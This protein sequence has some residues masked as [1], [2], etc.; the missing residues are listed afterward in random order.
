MS[1]STTRRGEIELDTPAGDDET[2]TGPDPVTVPLSYSIAALTL[3]LVLVTGGLATAISV[4]AGN[5]AVSET[6]SE[7]EVAVRQCFDSGRDNVM[8]LAANMLHMASSELTN[9]LSAQFSSVEAYT[10]T[11][12]KFLTMHGDIS[13]QYLNQTVREVMYSYYTAAASKSLTQSI[14]M[15]ASN[16]HLPFNEAFKG[17]YSEELFLDR[18]RIVG[19]IEHPGTV[20]R[21]FE[22]FHM[23]LGVEC[24]LGPK[25]KLELGDLGA[26]VQLGTP[27]EFGQVIVLNPDDPYS[28]KGCNLTAPYL[29]NGKVPSGRC[30]VPESLKHL[31]PAM[32]EAWS[33][34]PMEIRWSGVEAHANFVSLSAYASF[35]GGPNVATWPLLGKRTGIVYNGVDVSR[36]SKYMKMVGSK[37]HRNTRM[38]AVEIREKGGEREAILFGASHGETTHEKFACADDCND[39]LFGLSSK[40][41]VRAWHPPEVSL[42]AINLRSSG[43]HVLVTGVHCS[44]CNTSLTQALVD[45]KPGTFWVGDARNPL[46]LTLSGETT[47]DAF[48]FTTSPLSPATDPVGWVLEGSLDNQT[49]YRLYSTGDE[50]AVPTARSFRMPWISLPQTGHKFRHIRF[51]FTRIRVDGPVDPIVRTHAEYIRSQGGYAEVAKLEQERRPLLWNDGN[52]EYIYGV[53]PFNRTGREMYLVTIVKQAELLQVIRDSN[54]AVESEIKRS[55]EKVEEQRS[56]D[57]RNTIFVLV[58]CMVVLMLLSALLAKEATGSLVTLTRSIDSI[59]KMKLDRIHRN[60]DKVQIREVHTI[61]EAFASMVLQLKELRSYIPQSVLEGCS[62]PQESLVIAPQSGEVTLVFTDIVESTVLWEV[63][64]DAMNTALDM[65]NSLI[66]ELVAKYSGYEVKTIGDSFM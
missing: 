63:S 29:T 5:R 60:D 53:A 66:R 4:M 62:T 37:L 54:S 31:T 21:S 10:A 41:E 20:Q 2:Q 24:N 25:G 55:Q 1:V 35:E 50:A 43:Y 61:E 49:W 8:L 46:Y 42:S 48:T 52:V 36:A 15:V 26:G 56:S 28:T 47:V 58:G 34:P 39:W 19:Y 6:E 12:L 3:V 38:Y 30:D 17:G 27:D 44:G 14:V 16:R 9:L 40:G 7:Y 59:A 22:D 33:T 18:L 45:G 51:V 65:H 23:Y 64:P 57:F 13:K 32:Q 11:L